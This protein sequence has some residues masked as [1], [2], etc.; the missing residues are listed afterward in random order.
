MIVRY[1]AG[2]LGFRPDCPI[3]LL[4]RQAYAMEL[5]LHCL[6][7]RAQIEHIDI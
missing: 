7:V 2:T 1:E 4:E 6:E 3:E 5:Y